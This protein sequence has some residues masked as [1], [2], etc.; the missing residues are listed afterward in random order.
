[1]KLSE[2]LAIE[3]GGEFWSTALMLLLI[4]LMY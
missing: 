1:M 4:L 2:L 3:D